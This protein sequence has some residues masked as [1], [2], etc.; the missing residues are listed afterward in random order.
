MSR[1]AMALCSRLLLTIAITLVVG[2]AV[3][4]A[5]GYAIAEHRQKSLIGACRRAV[6]ALEDLVPPADGDTEPGGKRGGLV[7]VTTVDG[8]T[9][10]LGE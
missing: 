8:E 9:E 3:G 6:G 10:C 5:A 7:N 1:L 4:N 2:M